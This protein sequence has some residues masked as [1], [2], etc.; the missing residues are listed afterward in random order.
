M[1]R[2]P[3]ELS[4]ICHCYLTAVVPWTL[5][6]CFV[7]GLLHAVPSSPSRLDVDSCFTVRAGRIGSRLDRLRDAKRELSEPR[8]RE[9][10]PRWQA[11]RGVAFMSLPHL[12]RRSAFR[13]RV[14]SVSVP[15]EI[16]K[17]QSIDATSNRFRDVF[18][19]ERPLVARVWLSR[20]TRR[21]E[22]LTRISSVPATPPMRVPSWMPK[23]AYRA[24]RHSST[25][26][27]ASRSVSAGRNP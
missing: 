17:R 4:R 21:V 20:R 16:V 15:G 22:A 26:R 5:R 14:E 27:C 3:S 12:G 13:G 11:A 19:R 8:G 7:S 18:E 25:S 1:N 2:H 10:T 9:E 24:S 6:G 23:P